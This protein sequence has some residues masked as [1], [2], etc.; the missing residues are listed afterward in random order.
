MFPGT[1]GSY[2]GAI[3]G[4]VGVNEGIK[5]SGCTV[6]NSVIA[7]G[8]AIAAGGVVGSG[9]RKASVEGCTVT[10]CEISG[11][12]TVGGICGTSGVISN[13]TVK[14]DCS[15]SGGTWIG[16]IVGSMGESVTNCTNNAPVFGIKS[17][18]GIVGVYNG[19]TSPIISGC[20]NTGTVNASKTSA[21]GIIGG[22][23]SQNLTI[24]NC[25]N[26]GAVTADE[27][28]VG[29]IA[30]TLLMDVDITRCISEG[31]VTGQRDVG[32]I[33]GYID[34]SKGEHHVAG[35][36]NS[37]TYC[38]ISAEIKGEINVGGIVGT[39]DV[40]DD[41]DK[42]ATTIA[43]NILTPAASVSGTTNVGALIGDN[44]TETDTGTVK[45]N[46]WPEAAGAASGSGAGLF[47]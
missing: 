1:S 28:C 38:T 10:N 35:T 14:A 21:G 8:Y 36:P 22:T 40:V 7:G 47:L 30:G 26:S 11:S 31:S 44:Q 32:G 27:G 18:G 4:T 39:N 29:G 5:I 9:G 16:G 20:T 43:N 13:C 23:T 3:V 2:V 45:N 24:S 34:L 15:I 6:K 12:S 46:F 17:V 37:I 19:G 41:E 42:E 25:T 33:V